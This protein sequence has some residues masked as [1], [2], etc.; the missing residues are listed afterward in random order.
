MK[1]IHLIKEENM[2]LLDEIQNVNDWERFV[3]TC[4]DDGIS[5]F[6]SGSSAKLLSKEI[7][8]SMGG[9]NLSYH[10]YPF[11]FK[12]FLS[13]KNLKQKYYSS[14]EKAALVKLLREYLQFGGIRK[15]FFI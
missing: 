10:I 14:S 15:P 8:T 5:V 7:A 11:S 2:A 13:A 6:L 12:E 4:L 3:R 9:R 1:F